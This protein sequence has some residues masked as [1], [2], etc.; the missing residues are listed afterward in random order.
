[1]HNRPF[2]W[3]IPRHYYILSDKALA[4]HTWINLFTNGFNSRYFQPKIDIEYFPGKLPCTFAR[5]RNKRAKIIDRMPNKGVSIGWF[6]VA[7][8]TSCSATFRQLQAFSATFSLLSNFQ[9]IRQLLSFCVSIVTVMLL[10]RV[11]QLKSAEYKNI[12]CVENTFVQSFS[13]LLGGICFHEKVSL[14]NRKLQ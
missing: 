1:M 10:L 9:C 4:G 6:E 11:K 5:E 8:S 12:A 7:L 3:S 14:R 2:S 13:L